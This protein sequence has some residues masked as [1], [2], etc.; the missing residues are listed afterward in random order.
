ME[1]LFSKY[2]CGFRRGFSAQDCLLAMLGKWKSAV[3]KGKIFGILMADL[4]KAFDCLSHEL[5]I[6]KLNAYG[7][8][9]PALKLMQ[10][11]LQKESKELRLTKLIALGK[12]YYLEYHKD[13]YLAQSYS[14]FF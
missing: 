12:K 14:T 7:F 8:S 2:Q 11:Y 6:A 5:I 9:L 10:S 1:P 4:S 3:D 13:L